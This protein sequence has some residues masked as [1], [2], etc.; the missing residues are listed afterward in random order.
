MIQSQDLAYTHWKTSE[1]FPGRTRAE[2][3]GLCFELWSLGTHKEVE[4]S[5]SR[6]KII[7]ERRRTWKQKVFVFQMMSTFGGMMVTPVELHRSLKTKVW[8]AH[9][10]A[11]DTIFSTGNRATCSLDQDKP[12]SPAFQPL[13]DGLEAYLWSL[14]LDP[15][16]GWLVLSHSHLPQT[17]CRTDEC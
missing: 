7:F 10:L 1:F 9:T 4:Y 8:Q 17:W 14:H 12:C 13:W 15:S 5:P 3:A 6:M 16:T 11:W 2:Q